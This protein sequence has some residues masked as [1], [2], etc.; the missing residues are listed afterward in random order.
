MTGSSLSGAA[1]RAREFPKRVRT[2]VVLQLEVVDCGAACL[3]IVLA[4]YGRWVPLDELRLACGVGR[5]GSTAD[6]LA[7]AAGQF[8]ME[9][10]GWRKS[11]EQLKK[12]DVPAI[13]YWGMNH[14]V[15]FEGFKDG[16]FHLNDP[17]CGHRAVDHDTIDRDFTGIALSLEPNKDFRSGGRPPGALRRIWRLVRPYR[18]GL[19]FAATCGLL[20]ALP[21]AALPLLLS[22]LVDNVLIG[23]QQGWDAALVAVMAAAGLFVYV[24][25]WMQARSL[26][27]LSIRLSIV[28]ADRYVS[29]LL[30]LP[31]QFFA[32]RFAGD[33]ALRLQLIDQV[34]KFGV[35]QLAGLAV[36]LIVAAVF[37][38]IML[39]YDWALALVVL[40][41]GATSLL[42]TRALVEFRK[43][44]N[45]RL[46][47]EQGMLLGNGMAGVSAI[48]SVRA[49]SGENDFFER[50]AGKQ[51]TELQARQE[52][53]ELGHVVSSFPGLF[54]MLGSAAVLGLGGYRVIEGDM[55]IGVLMGFLVMAGNFLRPLGQIA[56]YSDQLETL[57]ADLQRL[58][59]I[60]RAPV[61]ETSDDGGSESSKSIAT[62]EGRLRLVGR[63]ELR[64]VRFGYQR[65]RK[66]IVE[67]I[68]LS[69]EPGERIAI[70]GPSGSGK[71]TLALMV[72]GVHKPWFG[73]VLFDGHP[74]DRIAREVLSPSIAFVDQNS[75]LFAGTLR[76]NLTMWNPE[77]PDDLIRAA[78][79]DASIHDDIMARPHG[80]DSIVEEGGKN[81]SGGQR[82]R[83]EIAR[84][85]VSNPSVLILDEATSNLDP[86]TEL[87]IDDALRRRNCTCLI[88]ATRLSTI[89]D[90][91]NTLVLDDGRVAEQGVH[92]EL[93]ADEN[94]IYSRLLKHG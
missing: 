4:H 12:L 13:L 85:L 41:L 45:H 22:L 88:V 14:F 67:D 39:A 19:A 29:R 72:A 7:K 64:N 79:E 61:A 20:L 46:R 94:S 24:L 75:V 35:G 1:R 52:F 26:R 71:T 60:F 28:Q 48:E 66:P 55:S 38:V 86:I 16:R 21:M 77:I 74:R 82:T 8:G 23:G 93:I 91:D 49:T 27:K 76:E 36:E 90:A 56:L 65:D 42:L 5:D 18:S 17:A 59:D 83:I 78:C 87:E 69:V 62:L 34:A 37:L 6:Q 2:P 43:D 9:L 25:T 53:T 70:V 84:A 31:I 92:E 89:R 3:G 44:G 51:A 47:R 30:R 54:E 81:F 50:W 57:E 73:D 32:H 33:L 58:D 40:A 10:S 15:V 80:Y 11:I 63:I 68:S